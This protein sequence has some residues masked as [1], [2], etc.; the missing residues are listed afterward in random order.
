MAR[1]PAGREILQITVDTEVGTRL[2]V[3]AALRRMTVG[4]LVEELVHHAWDRDDALN[5]W[6]HEIPAEVPA[7]PKRKTLH[8]LLEGTE[9]V[10]FGEGGAMTLK[11]EN[12]QAAEIERTY[13]KRGELSLRTPGKAPR[14]VRLHGQGPMASQIILEDR[15]APVAERWDP[16]RLLEALAAAGKGSQARLAQHF[17]ISSSTVRSWLQVG[18]VPAE[19]WPNLDEFFKQP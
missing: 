5:S 1:I 16:Q 19:W 7:K 17:K 14:P 11:D 12:A 3:K 4:R 13:G 18:R 6:I 2:R 15:D 10:E 9:D 8:E